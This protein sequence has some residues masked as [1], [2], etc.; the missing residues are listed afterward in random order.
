MSGGAARGDMQA[1]GEVPSLGRSPHFSGATVC[2]TAWL[3]R[4]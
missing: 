4:N 2:D 3:R 1:S